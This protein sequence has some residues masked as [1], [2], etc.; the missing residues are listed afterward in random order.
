VRFFALVDGLCL[1]AVAVTAI[2]FF[3]A[4]WWTPYFRN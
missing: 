1:I 3:A 4:C 2:V